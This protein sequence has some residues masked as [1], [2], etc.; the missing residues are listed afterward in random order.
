MEE[1]KQ[2][3]TRQKKCE[4]GRRRRRGRGAPAKPPETTTT[5]T[6][7]T[8]NPEGKE[9]ENILSILGW[10]WPFGGAVGREATR[11]GEGLGYR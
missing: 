10:A 2:I 9:G 1:Q 6:T 5:T 8:T 4:E 3:Q 7:T 11:D